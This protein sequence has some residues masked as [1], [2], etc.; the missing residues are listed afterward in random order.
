M[1][2]TVS[3]GQTDWSPYHSMFAKQLILLLLNI[4]FQVF[5][6]SQRIP[7]DDKSPLIDQLDSHMNSHPPK[8]A[9]PIKQE[10]K[11][12]KWVESKFP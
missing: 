3:I 7:H 6:D 12:L 10:S 11:K 9:K 2:S 4:C 1:I 8:Q 5:F